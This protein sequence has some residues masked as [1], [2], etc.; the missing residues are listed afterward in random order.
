[1]SSVESNGEHWRLLES[2]I[3]FW[4]APILITDCQANLIG[5]NQSGKRLLQRGNI[6]KNSKGRIAAHL[7][8]DTARL[9]AHIEQLTRPRNSRTFTAMTFTAARN[10][11]TAAILY[12]IRQG[13]PAEPKYVLFNV[14][15]A[16]QEELFIGQGILKELFGLTEAEERVALLVGQGYSPQQMV[17]RLR[18][19]M[20][21]IRTHLSRIYGK[22]ESRTQ[23]DFLRLMGALGVLETRLG[24]D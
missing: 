24:T 7:P 13:H 10:A 18:V 5:S 17:Q 21:T 9:Y 15:D 8:S 20:P 4:R 3:G 23:R 19:S 12:A 6:L 22:T 2:I 14:I 1:V 11:K 16:R